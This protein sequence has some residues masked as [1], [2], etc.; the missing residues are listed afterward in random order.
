M[1]H[2]VKWKKTFRELSDLNCYLRLERSWGKCCRSK[3][4]RYSNSMKCQGN[5]RILRLW[6]LEMKISLKDMGITSG[7]NVIEKRWQVYYWQGQESWGRPKRIAEIEIWRSGESRDERYIDIWVICVE[8]TDTAIRSLRKEFVKVNS[9]MGQIP[10][11][12]PHDSNPSSATYPT[13]GLE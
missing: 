2:E 8:V 5:E 7:R 4:P 1:K 9:I 10:E 11:P 12:Q 3:T 13:D 6:I